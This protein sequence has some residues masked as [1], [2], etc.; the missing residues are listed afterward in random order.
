[1]GLP[2]MW[3][4]ERQ[5]CFLYDMLSTLHTS[6]RHE[7]S[8]P[9][10]INSLEA[11]HVKKKPERKKQKIMKI[12]IQSIVNKVSDFHCLVDAAKPDIIIGTESWLSAE[13][14]DNEVPQG[15]I[16]FSADKV[17]KTIRTEG[18]IVL[19]S[20]T[21]VCSEQPQLKSD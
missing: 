5:H 16:P 21:V 13:I 11:K 15:Y 7:C 17:S 3:T 10:Q 6:N 19:V 8:L 20:D 12:N 4:A 18:V 2:D 14:M 1:M 9:D